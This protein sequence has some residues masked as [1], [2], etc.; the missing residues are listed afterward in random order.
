MPQPL[1]EP[2]DGP[3]STRGHIHRWHVPF[4]LVGVAGFEPTTSSS[5]T[6]SSSV[7]DVG[8]WLFALVRVLVLVGLARREKR[9]TG[10][11]SPRS[12]PI[13]RWGRWLLL[14]PASRRAGSVLPGRARPVQVERP[15]GRTTWTGRARSG[16]LRCATGGAESAGHPGAARVQGR[17]ALAAGGR[18][19][20]VGPE[21]LPAGGAV[22]A[23]SVAV[24]A[25]HPM[26][27]AVA[28]RVR[29]RAGRTGNGRP[30][31]GHGRAASL[32]G[33]S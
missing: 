12:L 28:V 23:R 17:V 33:N 2:S 13:R 10:R 21:A 16:C 19:R 11:S 25:A 32:V 15:A 27:G 4:D 20:V 14:V 30:R 29:W 1:G 7:W 26:S 8:A 6:R 5:R 31:R 24:C 9:P 22:P 3:G 18:V